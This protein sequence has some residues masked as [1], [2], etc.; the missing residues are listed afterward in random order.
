MTQLWARAIKRHRIVKSETVPLEEGGFMDA[1]VELSQ[2]L[3][4]SRPMMLGKNERE[5]EQFGLTSF[6]AD[7]FVESIPYDKIEIETFG[8]DAKKKRSDDPRNG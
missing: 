5:M 6:T 3:D 4:I 2:K 1:L 7:N 8:P